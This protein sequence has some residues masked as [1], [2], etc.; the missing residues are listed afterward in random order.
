MGFMG[1]LYELANAC[2]LKELRQPGGVFTK[3]NVPR[4]QTG[5]TL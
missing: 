1:G 5:G 3:K 2:I 4:V